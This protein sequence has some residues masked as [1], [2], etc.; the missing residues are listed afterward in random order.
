MQTVNWSDAYSVGDDEIDRQHKRL[1]DIINELAAAVLAGASAPP[2]AARKIFD[3]LAEYVT[4][5]FAYEEQRIA[6]AGYPIDKV[7]AHRR[8]HREILRR[9]QRFEAHLDTNGLETMREL[10]PFL[11][12]DWLVNHIC[13]VDSDYASCLA[14]ERASRG[15]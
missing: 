2:G 13:V 8:E 14:A 5:H 3:R 7:E 9:L 6:D 4:T 15:N 11:Y 10:L 12:G 1:L